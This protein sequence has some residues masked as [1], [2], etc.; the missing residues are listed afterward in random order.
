M[1]NTNSCERNGKNGLC[2]LALCVRNLCKEAFIGLKVGAQM[3]DQMKQ[4]MKNNGKGLTLTTDSGALGG[5]SQTSTMS[6]IFLW[7][8]DNIG[9]PKGLQQWLPQHIEDAAIK[10]AMADN[11]VKIRFLE[12]AWNINQDSILG[13]RL[14]HQ[15]SNQKK[16][17]N[18]CGL[19]T[20]H[21]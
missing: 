18:K 15:S 14:E 9:G 7:F 5:E 17:W 20:G 19:L 13:T 10:E 8:Q 11:D 6:R 2:M 4:Q 3:E 16:H 21:A 12:H 1:S